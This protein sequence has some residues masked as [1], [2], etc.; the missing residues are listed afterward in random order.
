MLAK[1]NEMNRSRPASA[2]GPG[3]QQE[4]SIASAMNLEVKGQGGVG[5]GERVVGDKRA[6]DNIQEAIKLH[7][8]GKLEQA[9]GMFGRLAD[10]G[11]ENNALSQVLYALALRW[12]KNLLQSLTRCVLGRT[13]PPRRLNICTEITS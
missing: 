13:I 11:G 10:P 8:A 4:R 5:N 12:V 7:E 2:Q 9:T 3:G 1:S 6:D